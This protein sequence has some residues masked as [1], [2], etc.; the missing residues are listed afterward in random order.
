[1]KRGWFIGDFNPSVL[2]TSDFEVGLLTHKK[3]E[4]WPIHVHKLCIEYNLLVEG[5]MT[6]NG[7]SISPGTIFVIDKNEISAPT[8]LED[9]LIL[10]VKTP[11]IPRDKYEIF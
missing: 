8:F 3:N 2:R 7:V 10:C 9:C 4:V 1:M 11:S 5:R 6:I